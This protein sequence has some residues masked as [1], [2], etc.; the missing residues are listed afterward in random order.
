MNTKRLIAIALILIL[1]LSLTACGGGNPATTPG[2]TPSGKDDPCPCCSNCIQE[3][4]ECAKCGDSD[5]C[6]CKLPDGGDDV[7]PPL[8]YNI[9]IETEL[10]CDECNFD[11]CGMI[12]SGSAIVTMNFIDRKT[13]YWGR[14]ADGTGVTAKNG[15][16]E[17][18]VKKTVAYGDL[19][20]YRFTAELSVPSDHKTYVG[21]DGDYKTIFVSVDKFGPD[22]ATIDWTAWGGG[23]ET[24]PSFLSFI[25]QGLLEYA[26]PSDV[27]TAYPDP[28]TGSFIFEMPLM[29]SPIRVLFT[30]GEV[31]CVYITLTPTSE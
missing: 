9:E 8:T 11:G 6:K 22:E 15:T 30:W 31:L 5:G 7:H 1:T 13:G 21:T 4:C 29:D 24:A 3:E 26:E 28:D 27:G 10:M 12:T 18:A 17:L 14:S 19:P 25:Y 2:E 16:H 20:N 23:P